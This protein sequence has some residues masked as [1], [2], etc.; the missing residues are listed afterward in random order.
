MVKSATS[1]S[2]SN[3]SFSNFISSLHVFLFGFKSSP[4][5][6]CLAPLLAL[7]S[8]FNFCSFSF[9]LSSTVSLF[10][11]S[12]SR[13]SLF[14]ISFLLSLPVFPLFG[15]PFSFTDPFSL[16]L[17]ASST[18]SLSSISLSFSSSLSLSSI[19]L[20][21]CSITTSLFFASFP[22]SNS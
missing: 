19:S 21:S 11:V 22:P 13:F 10:P 1:L 15:L 14:S 9:S 17:S 5:F 3:L 7:S 2:S 4:A 16:S 8:I 20:H 18:F 12:F 6:P